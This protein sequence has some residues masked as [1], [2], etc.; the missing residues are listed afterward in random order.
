[1]HNGLAMFVRPSFR[2]LVL[3][4]RLTLY[5]KFWWKIP[6]NM[7]LMAAL[8]RILP[9]LQFQIFRCLT[10]VSSHGSWS[11]PWYVLRS[12]SWLTLASYN[13]PVPLMLHLFCVWILFLKKLNLVPQ[14]DIDRLQFVWYYVHAVKSFFYTWCLHCPRAKWSLVER[15]SSRNM[16]E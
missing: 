13:F 9:F 8:S 16:C 4:N 3:F 2:M 15:A 1:M 10:K 12:F 7:N 5:S 14:N 11:Q 6:A